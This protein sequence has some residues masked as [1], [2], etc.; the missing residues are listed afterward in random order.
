MKSDKE[1]FEYYGGNLPP[2]VREAQARIKALEEENGL[3]NGAHSNLFAKINE[4]KMLIGKIESDLIDCQ[5]ECLEDKPGREGNLV[6]LINQ[7]AVAQAWLDNAKVI[8]N[9]I[10]N[11]QTTF[12]GRIGRARRPIKDLHRYEDVKAEI[13]KAKNPLQATVPTS[14]LRHLAEKL[15]LEKDMVAF[16]KGLEVKPDKVEPEAA[17]SEPEAKLEPESTKEM[18]I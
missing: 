14:S 11:R 6:S 3:L 10:E 1:L 9:E 16:L 17:V 15:G 13:L 8:G 7:R 5:I 18:A 2:V 4:M 12:G